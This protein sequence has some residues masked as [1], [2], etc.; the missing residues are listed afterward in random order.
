[1]RLTDEHVE[2]WERDGYVV[3]E[4]FLAGDELQAVLENFHRY[5]PAADDFYRHRQRYHQLETAQM[6]GVKEFPFAGFAMNDTITHP[7]VISFAERVIG[8][9]DVHCTHG[10]IWAKYA[11]AS[12]YEQEM[13]CDYPT[14]DLVYPR[15]D[16]KW[17]QVLALL[18]LTDV[19]PDLGPTGIVSK[20]HS[21]PYDKYYWPPQ[22]SRKDFP[23]LYEHEVPLV[24]RAGTL[25]LY[26]MTTWHRG[27]GM[28]AREGSRFSMTS[29]YR[30]AGYESMGWRAWPREALQP[31]MKAWLVHATPRQ[32][33]VI[34]FPAPGHPYWTAETLL[35]AARRYPKMDMTPYRDALRGAAALAT[36]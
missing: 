5:F 16:G 3:V 4:D 11:G 7:E 10:Q 8:T 19:T 28:R 6:A 20:L 23:D 26:S 31:S 2:I 14:N 15:Q 22:R 24:A 25:L 32:R 13:H 34:G 30:H 17:R 29:V 35:G 27:T 36:V 12:D 1:M 21:A 33:E 9:A 18:Y